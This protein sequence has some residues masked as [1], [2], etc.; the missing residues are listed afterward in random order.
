MAAAVDHRSP[1]VATRIKSGT[2]ALYDQDFYAWSR[3]QAELLRSGRVSE[4]DLEH[5]T[6]AVKD[7]VMR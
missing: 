2:E 3:A 5:L 4:L 7:L 6:D 1:D